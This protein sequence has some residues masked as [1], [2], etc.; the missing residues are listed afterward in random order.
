MR[1]NSA[2]ITYLNW[3]IINLYEITMNVWQVIF[4]ICM[5]SWS[6]LI[7]IITFIIIPWLRILKLLG[8]EFKFSS[9]ILTI[10]WQKMHHFCFYHSLL[11][12]E[13]FKMITF[14]QIHLDLDKDYKLFVLSKNFTN[15]LISKIFLF[16]QN[17]K[18]DTNKKI[19]CKNL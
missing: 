7:K 3:S 2:D 12:Y 11:L 5:I 6:L 1:L 4:W 9:L 8:I 18:L 15:L 10:K 16:Y 17:F 13:Q 19:F 14:Y